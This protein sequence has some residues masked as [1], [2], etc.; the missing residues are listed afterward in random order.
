MSESAQIIKDQQVLAKIFQTA[1][2]F[3]SVYA[4]NCL[5]WD[6]CH[7]DEACHK[8][9]KNWEKTGRWW[10]FIWIKPLIMCRL[11]QLISMKV[12]T[13]AEVD[14]DG[15]CILLLCSLFFHML[16]LVV[17]WS[18]PPRSTSPIFSLS[19]P[20]C[21]GDKSVT[22]SSAFYT[23]HPRRCKVLASY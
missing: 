1:A 12:L 6:Y 20:L 22:T 7:I 21:R 15:F 5:L 3:K 17:C 14:S 11:H 18:A 8:R 10:D 2:H 13:R 4:V 16:L 23:G 9:T 19:P